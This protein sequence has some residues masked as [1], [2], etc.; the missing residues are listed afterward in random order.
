VFFVFYLV[1]IILSWSDMECWSE[2]PKAS[3]TLKQLSEFGSEGAL[4]KPESGC[5]L[6][7]LLL[8]G[9]STPRSGSALFTQKGVQTTCWSLK[10]TNLKLKIS[11]QSM[12]C[13]LFTSTS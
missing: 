4:F 11:N 7:D 3:Q 12:L 10:T 5:S 13:Q 1:G 6:S 9:N 8:F 2:I